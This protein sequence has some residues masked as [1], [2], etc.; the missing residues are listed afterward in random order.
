MTGQKWSQWMFQNTSGF[1]LSRQGTAVELLAL[2]VR[3]E[4]ILLFCHLAVPKGPALFVPSFT[5]SHQ[6]KNADGFRIP[7]L[8]KMH[9]LNILWHD[10][11]D[12]A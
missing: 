6:V 8:E 4:Q 3:P 9:R 7:D 5:R 12:K 10:L 11:C 1:L 2:Q